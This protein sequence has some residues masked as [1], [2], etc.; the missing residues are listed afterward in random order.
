MISPGGRRWTGDPRVG[1]STGCGYTAFT[2]PRSSTNDRFFL[3]MR[4]SSE[5]RRSAIRARRSSCR[6]PDRRQR[7]WRAD[8]PGE[9]LRQALQRVAV[10]ARPAVGSG[11]RARQLGPTRRRLRRTVEHASWFYEAVSFSEAMKSQTPGLGQ[12]YLGSYN[13][14]N[15][16]WLDG[17]KNYTIHVPA[18]PPA[19]LFWSLTVYDVET[20]CLIDNEQQRGDHGTTTRT[21]TQMPTAR[22]TC[23]SGRQH[24]MAKNRLDS[25]HPRQT[26]VLVLPVLRSTRAV[27]RPQLETRR[28]HANVATGDTTADRRSTAGPLGSS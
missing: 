20:R 2:S 28:H 17:S 1:W 23:T 7:R 25:I 14:I 10:L 21:F 6:D 26:L 9:H 15:G 11:N 12:A 18:D 19:K 8:G 22:S 5:S 4:N 13:D 27:L 24:P 16:E 3:A